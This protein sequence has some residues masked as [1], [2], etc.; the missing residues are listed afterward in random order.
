MSAGSWASTLYYDLAIPTPSLGDLSVHL[1]A[2]RQ[3]QLRRCSRCVWGQLQ[4][5]GNHAKGAFIMAVPDAKSDSTAASLD[6]LLIFV[7]PTFEV[8][9]D[10]TSALLSCGF[11]PSLVSRS[12][13]LT[14][15]VTHLPDHMIDLSLFLLGYM[16]SPLDG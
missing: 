3:D 11:I 7:Q 14:P 9:V 15:Q 5:P 13:W 16:N 6:A 2:M 8:S 10:F 4:R 1:F 12:R